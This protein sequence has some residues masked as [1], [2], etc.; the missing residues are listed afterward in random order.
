[1]RRKPGTYLERARLAASKGRDFASRASPHVRRV[2]HPRSVT[3]GRWFEELIHAYLSMRGR[4]EASAVEAPRPA[5]EA[6]IR[7]TCMATAGLGASSAG[8]VTA[9]ETSFGR[10]EAALAAPLAGMVVGAD[11]LSRALLHVR[12]VDRLA[13]L[14]G[15]QFGR[16]DAAALARLYALALGAVEHREPDD[17]GAELVE[18]VVGLETQAVLRALGGNALGES[19]LRNIVPFANVLT[20][21]WASWRLTARLGRFFQE[22]FIRR[23]ALDDALER[24][25]ADDPELRELAVDGIWFLFSADGRLTALETALLA[26]ILQG[27]PEDTRG[28]LAGRLVVDESGWLRR[29]ATTVDVP[30]RARVADVLRT[31]AAIDGRLETTELAILRSACDALSQPWDEATVEQLARELAERGRVDLEA[32]ESRASA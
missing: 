14:A 29:L 5:A 4:A 2:L 30:A 23:R 22:Y 7:R 20:S 21:P 25:D 32:G 15:I 3:T 31:A 17:P 24:L 11:M 8:A 10:P 19:L 16:H 18:R 13:E 27:S 28:D 12:M 6:L 9:A 26:E 1:M